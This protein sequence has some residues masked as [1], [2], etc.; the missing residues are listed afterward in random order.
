MLAVS[1]WAAVVIVLSGDPNTAGRVKV[2]QLPSEPREERGGKE[3]VGC[4]VLHTWLGSQT[5]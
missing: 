3:S 2:P 5:D 4:L 1:L